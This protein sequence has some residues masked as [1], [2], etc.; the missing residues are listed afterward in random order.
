MI[1]KLQT[2]SWCS[3]PRNLSGLHGD[4]EIPGSSPTIVCGFVIYLFV[5]L[6]CLFVC[7]NYLNDFLHG[8][9]CNIC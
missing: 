8:Y 2:S 7:F 5:Y 6:L 4:F 9:D 3:G 1:Q